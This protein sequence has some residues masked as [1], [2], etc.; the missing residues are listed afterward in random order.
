MKL[1]AIVLNLIVPGAGMI[2]VKSEAA[3]MAVA[4]LYGVTA[5]AGALGLWLIPVDMPRAATSGALA[6]ASIIW[7]AGQWLLWRQL[8]QLNRGWR[9]HGHATRQ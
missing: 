8:W 1:A 6:A 2:L 7:V 4:L 9:W 3:G 5:Q